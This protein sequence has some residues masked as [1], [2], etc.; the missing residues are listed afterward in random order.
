MSRYSTWRFNYSSSLRLPKPQVEDPAVN[1][2]VSWTTQESPHTR[3]SIA[4]QT[5]S[6]WMSGPQE[7]GTKQR[8]WCSQGIV[9]VVVPF[10]GTNSGTPIA[11]QQPYN[12][13]RGWYRVIGGALSAVRAQCNYLGVWPYWRP[14]LSDHRGIIVTLLRRF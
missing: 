10:I 9:H 5:N 14:M 8:P 4:T 3:C 6:A 12:N 13:V 2:T 7:N 11:G 1:L